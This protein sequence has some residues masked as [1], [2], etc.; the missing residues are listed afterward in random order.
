M[1]Q[2][3]R[4][5]ARTS[6]VSQTL[7]IFFL[8]ICSQSGYA[9]GKITSKTLRKNP[10]SALLEMQA[11]Y[12]DVLTLTAEFTQKQTNVTL[13]TTKET[14]GRI[15]IKRPNMFRWQTVM[16]ESEISI[17]VGNG[18]KVWFYKPPFRAGENG[19][20]LIREAADVQSQLAIDLLAGHANVSKDFKDKTLSEGHFE[21]K[22][23]KPAG[24]IEHIELFLEKS[25][26]LVY[27]LVLFTSTGNQ[28]ELTLK[29]VVLGPQLSDKMFTFT[30]PPK[31]EEIY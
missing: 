25:T 23:L 26:N 7:I 10:K 9:D 11:K 8:L 15:F 30:T 29:D 16:P 14:S 24:D 12:K 2:Q 13:G 18:K 3:F 20:V 6:Q 28:T 19:Q 22:P 4:T 5:R 17:L 21:L 1:N 31:T 27:K